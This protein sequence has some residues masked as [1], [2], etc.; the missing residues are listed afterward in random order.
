MKALTASFLLG[1]LGCGPALRTQEAPPGLPPGSFVITATQIQ[2]TGARTAWQVLRQSAPMLQAV[3]D[4]NGRP[5]KLTRRGR[6]SFLLDDPPM[7][8]L[9]EV[10]VLDFRTLDAIE[11]ESIHAIFILDGIEGT[12]YYGTNSVSG[13]I[14]IKTKDGRE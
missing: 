5:A 14:L 3:E 4:E 10:R 13:V 2:G 11:A 1:L 7:I 6:S 9:D 12:T 8:V